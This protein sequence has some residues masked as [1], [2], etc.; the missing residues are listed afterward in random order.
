M[1]SGTMPVND[2]RATPCSVDLIK[3][4]GL[5]DNQPQ[6]CDV[7]NSKYDLFASFKRSKACIYQFALSDFED[8]LKEIEDRVNN[9]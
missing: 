6:N 8:G 4:E 5:R 1:I 7:E 2:L 3:K 9:P